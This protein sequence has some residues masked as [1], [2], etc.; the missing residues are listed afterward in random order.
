MRSRGRPPSL[1]ELDDVQTD[2]GLGRAVGNLKGAETGQSDTALCQVVDQPVEGPGP[3][4]RAEELARR[5]F[6]KVHQAVVG[7]DHQCDHTSAP[8]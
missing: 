8:D 4:R 7:G 3:V 5:V 2:P 6:E 1:R